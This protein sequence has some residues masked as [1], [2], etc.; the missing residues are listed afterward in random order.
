MSLEIFIITL[1]FLLLFFFLI[2]KKG[3]RERDL[4]RRITDIITSQ[5]KEVRGSVDSTSKS[6]HDQITNFTKETVKL[7][8]EMDEI[9]KAMEGVSSFQEFF[10]SPKARGEWGEASLEHLLKEYFPSELF[11]MQYGF[12]SG[13]KVDAVLKLPDKKLLPIDAKFP[14]DNFQNMVQAEEME[15]KEFYR[16]KFLEDVKKKIKDVSSKYILPEEGTVDFAIIFIPAEAVYYEIN[17]EKE[18]DIGQFARERK[19]V[20]SSPNTIFLTLRAIE[21]WFRDSRISKKTQ[22][23][24]RRLDKVKKDGEIL[25]EEFEKL[26]K[27]LSNAVSSYERSDKR[28]EMFGDKMDRL[29]EEKDVKKL[30]D[31]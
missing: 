20:L 5:L 25:K 31:K 19:V 13:E 1:I 14:L 11:K 3:E 26:G 6:M 2:F 12:Q 4:E 27:H 16:K 17:M 21:H 18:F 29:L 10:R 30:D 15:K 24:I 7:R 22:E 28:L 9:Q 23:I 8:E